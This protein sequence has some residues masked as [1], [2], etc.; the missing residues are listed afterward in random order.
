[1]S[2][3]KCSNCGRDAVVLVVVCHGGAYW[4]ICASCYVDP[5]L[6]REQ[7]KGRGGADSAPGAAKKFDELDPLLG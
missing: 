4:R 3:P 2:V 1:M 7:Q 5:P 6:A